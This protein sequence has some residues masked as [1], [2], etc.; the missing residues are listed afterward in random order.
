MP[1]T[2][3][4]MKKIC[5]PYSYFTLA[6]SPFSNDRQMRYSITSDTSDMCS[7]QFSPFCLSLEITAT[8]ILLL[9]GIEYLC[10]LNRTSDNL[11]VLCP[12]LI[13]AFSARFQRIF[14]ESTLYQRKFCFLW[15]ICL[16]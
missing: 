15:K 3:I 8:I 4:N 11:V 7:K 9:K 10:S 1:Q 14:Y 6:T 13:L 12:F 2:I 5:S 16:S